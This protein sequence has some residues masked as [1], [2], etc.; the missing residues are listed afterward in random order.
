METIGFALVTTGQSID[1]KT[2]KD[3]PTKAPR[4]APH[5]VKYLTL[6]GSLP[7]SKASSTS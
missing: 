2:V 4:M 6:L 5:R 7:V 3:A 1:V